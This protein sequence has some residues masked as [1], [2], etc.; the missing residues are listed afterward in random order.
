VEV[1]HV[2]IIA[3]VAS[4]AIFIA[5]NL[6]MLIKAFRTKDLA[7]YSL[8]HITLSNLGNLIYWLYVL[9]LPVGP[10][11]FLHGFFTVSTALMLLFYLRYEKGWE[12]LSTLCRSRNFYS[13]ETRATIGNVGALRV[14][15]H[16]R[17]SEYNDGPTHYDSRTEQ[18]P[19]HTTVVTRPA[20]I[21]R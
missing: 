8:G 15:G 5:S 12:H 11:W 3:G 2:P 13:M 18:S 20:P 16:P 21:G 10:I 4:S 1:R 17:C 9:A 6:P 19:H 14:S 7:S